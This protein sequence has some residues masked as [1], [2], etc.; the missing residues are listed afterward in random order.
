MKTMKKF[1]CLSILIATSALI[2]CQKQETAQTEPQT[3]ATPVT[4]Q[5]QVAQV[6]SSQTPVVENQTAAETAPEPSAT[7][8]QL[9][10]FT[11]MRQRMRDTS[12]NPA[13][14][15]YETFYTKLEPLGAWFETSDYGYV[16]QPR[17]AQSSRS[18][19]PYTNGRWVYTD[20]GW[21]WISDEPFGW[22]A[23]HYGRWTRL[24]DIGWVWV[25]GEEWAPAW[26][27]W[28]TGKDYVGWAPL[29]PEARFD[30]GTG[31]HKWADNYYDIGPDQYAF[32]AANEFGAPDVH[33]ALLPR[34]RNV[35]LIDQ[36]INVT[37]ISYND[38]TVENQGPN[39]EDLRKRS[40]E[41]I[42]QLHLK[43]ENILN[44]NFGGHA[45]VQGDAVVVTAPIVAVPQRSDRPPS[46]KQ[47]ITQ[48]AVDL[49]W[50]QITDR[51][52]AEKARKKMKS[53]APPP[54]NAPPKQFGRP[55]GE[56]SSTFSASPSGSAPA[57]T[58][59]RFS[60]QRSVQA[61]QPTPTPEVST[62]PITPT[63]PAQSATASARSRLL[64]PLESPTPHESATP[65]KTSPSPSATTRAGS[66]ASIPP[67]ATPSPIAS[68]KKHPEIKSQAQ[69]FQPRRVVP[70]TSPESASPSASGSPTAANSEE[71]K[72]PARERG[73][74]KKAANE[75]PSPTPQPSP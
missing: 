45:T 18:W 75:R 60:P 62:A 21:T 42:Q 10:H 6:E 47:T 58:K 8:K 14:A 55:V 48:T 37:D 25:P 73:E 54:T 68:P 9:H 59:S 27:S 31:I 28:R 15:T 49:G 30:R 39:F 11:S 63:A 44:E 22:A 52:A 33:N 35:A 13:T 70:M 4:E 1:F 71:N 29:P 34:E 41:P 12:G 67:F 56:A 69:K 40:R 61:P 23:Y 19:R 17:E 74:R 50:D 20:A 7:A 38:T 32:V 3:Q 72:K 64:K 43:R 51:Q 57:E 46:V 53:E 36:T 5:Q 65:T 2:S 16:W 66:N 26:V 24:R